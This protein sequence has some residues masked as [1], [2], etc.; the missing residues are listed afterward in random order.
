MNDISI[1]TNKGISLLC[2][3]NIIRMESIGNVWAEV[4]DSLPRYAGV[5]PNKIPKGRHRPGFRNTVI[6]PN[7]ISFLNIVARPSIQPFFFLLSR[8]KYFMASSLRRTR[9]LNTIGEL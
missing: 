8:Q 7:D 9:V 3:Q 5:F 6:C 2:L 1:P 4:F